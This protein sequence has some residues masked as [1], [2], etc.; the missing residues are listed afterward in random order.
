M[1]EVVFTTG[2]GIDKARVSISRARFLNEKDWLKAIAKE[3]QIYVGQI[4]N[5][6]EKN[7]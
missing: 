5:V 2:Y 1:S 6:K 7:A 4:L 3:L